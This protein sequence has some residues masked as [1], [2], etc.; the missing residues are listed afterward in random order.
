MDVTQ[1]NKQKKVKQGSEMISYWRLVCQED[2]DQ[3]AEKA[4]YRRKKMSAGH[5][6]AI[7]LITKC[8]RDSCNSIAKTQ[9]SD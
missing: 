7:E 4:T 9:T 3:C 8:L 2:N 6:A 5:I 1:K